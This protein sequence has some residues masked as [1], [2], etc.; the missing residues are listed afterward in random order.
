[1]KTQFG[2]YQSERALL[3]LINFRGA[4]EPVATVPSYSNWQSTN[5][6]QGELD[7][8]P[9]I[10]SVPQEESLPWTTNLAV[11]RQQQG[12]SPSPLIRTL[13]EQVQ[14][15]ETE[16]PKQTVMIDSGEPFNNLAAAA[17]HLTNHS[18]GPIQSASGT[19]LSTT[20]VRSE[21]KVATL[22]INLAR[23]TAQSYTMHLGQ[24]T[25]TLADFRA[26]ATN[27]IGQIIP[28]AMDTSRGNYQQTGNYQIAFATSDGQQTSANLTIKPTLRKFSVTWPLITI[29][30]DDSRPSVASFGA[31][32]I[33]VNG[34][35]SPIF[36]DFSQVNYQQVGRYQV[37]LIAD[38]GQ[39]Q[40]VELIILP[41]KN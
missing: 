11:Q 25:A 8:R 10:H 33:D 39:R 19:C 30:L 7:F 37:S 5:H 1:M 36:A 22:A 21:T 16:K 2:S 27:Q 12:Q 26:Q 23:I 14:G 13:N 40:T 6:R 38:D 28:V 4:T 20:L 29:N 31:I 24:A 41:R 18:Q 34:H 35:S 9:S 15:E 3:K 32:A 17:N